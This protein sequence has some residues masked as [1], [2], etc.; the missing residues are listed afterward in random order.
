MEAGTFLCDLDGTLFVHG[1]TD[2]LPG[3]ME[4]LRLVESAGYRIVFVTRR[5]DAEFAD[6][7]VYSRAATEA[8]LAAHG[9]GHHTIVY[10]V[11]SPRFLVDDSPIQAISRP[12]G[13]G[14]TPEWLDDFAEAIGSGDEEASDAAEGGE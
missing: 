14:F 9:L 10:D 4:F 6:H 7:P 13:Q 12:S 3:A 8:M 1:T 2:P 5:G 11:R